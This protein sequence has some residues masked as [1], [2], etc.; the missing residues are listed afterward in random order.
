MD[1]YIKLSTD[2]TN[3]YNDNDITNNNNNMK[4]IDNTPLNYKLLNWTDEKFEYYN[5]VKFDTIGDGSCFLHALLMSF[6][7]PY[8][9][10]RI[11]R[12][13]FVRDLRTNLSKKLESKVN[14]LDQESKIYYDIISNG[15]L[16]E[17]SKFIPEFSQ[18]SLVKDLDSNKYLSNIYNEFISDLLNRDIYILDM[19]KKDVYM[20]GTDFNILYKNRLS[21]V[22]LYTQ[23][24]K[25][26]TKNHYELIGILNSNNTVRV[27]FEP[28]DKFIISIRNRMN[29]LI[30]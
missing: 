16:R 19:N 5:M 7:K 11:N 10:N 12:R 27:G 8:Q 18:Q 22:I 17:E 26:E 13:Q 29:L 1:K 28:D 24:I 14:P 3:T 6:Y 4:K 9:M 21:T 23:N 25:F 20:T 30:K 2:I 15:N